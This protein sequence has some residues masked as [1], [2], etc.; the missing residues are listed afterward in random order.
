MALRLDF[1]CSPL[2]MWR[3]CR[4]F[5]K[6]IRASLAEL[7]RFILCT[8]GLVRYMR[9]FVDISD[10][11]LHSE[12]VVSGQ[13]V[14]MV[15]V[16]LT[17]HAKF[18]NANFDIVPIIILRVDAAL[19]QMLRKH[20]LMCILASFDL[21]DQSASC[22]GEVAHAAAHEAL[23]PEMLLA[24]GAGRPL[25]GADAHQ[26]TDF[27]SRPLVAERFIDYLRGWIILSCAFV[28]EL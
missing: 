21:V 5:A 11:L 23:P 25:S 26:N 13:P 17:I 7:S 6:C 16:N 22:F 19:R 24:V 8:S 3:S 15:Q 1:V 14:K 18:A 4:L 27:A 20:V 12:G 2:E 9:V 28:N 10:S